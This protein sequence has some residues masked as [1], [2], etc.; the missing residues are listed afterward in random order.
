LVQC[1]Y[2]G[3]KFIVK[4]APPPSEP[5]AASPALDAAPAADQGRTGKRPLALVFVV[6][7]TLSYGLSLWGASLL[8]GIMAGIMGG[9]SGA[10]EDLPPS[11]R[12]SAPSVS[13]GVC[14]LVELAAV[15]TLG[16][17]LSHFAGAYGL[18]THQRWG[19]R[20]ARIVYAINAALGLVG[21]IV[22]IYLRG[23]ILISGVYLGASVAI[24]LYLSGTGAVARLVGQYIPAPGEAPPDL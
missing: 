19:V 8:W 23:A 1:K 17:A 14:L 16:L 10:L 22:A 7:L 5:P 15:V 18:W 24:L 12:G 4:A 20:M 6:F 9:V 21:F 13:R 2:C 11:L 3:A